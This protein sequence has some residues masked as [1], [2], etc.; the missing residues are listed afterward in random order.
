MVHRGDARDEWRDL[1]YLFIENVGNLV[2]PAI[3]DLGQAANVVALS[4][5]EGE[6]KPLKYPVMF[7][8]AD[9]VL[10]T[11]IDLLPHLP[12]ISLESHRGQPREGDA[13]AVVPAVSSQ[14]GEG[15]AAWSTWLE[16]RRVAVPDACAGRKVTAMDEHLERIIAADEDAR[17]HVASATHAATERIEHARAECRLRAEQAADSAS[18][19]AR[20]RAAQ[21]PDGDGSNHRGAPE[22]ARAI[23]GGST[24]GGRTH[25]G[26]G[27]RRLRADRA[28]G[29]IAPTDHVIA[30]GSLAYANARVRAL[31]SRLLGREIAA[32]VAA[33]LAA[34][35]DRARSSDTS[36][37]EWLAW[38]AVVLGS[39]PTGQA[40]VHSLLHRYDIENL[41][42]AWRAIVH[43]HAER[44]WIGHWIDLGRARERA[45]GRGSRL[46][47][48]RLTGRRRCGAR[49]L[50]RSPRPCG[51][52]TRTIRWPPRSAS[53]DGRRARS[54]TPLERCL[55]RSAPPPRS[56]G[57][58]VR[59]RDFAVVRR[60]GGRRPVTRDPHRRAWLPATTRSTPAS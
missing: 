1:D 48:A 51:A 47:H 52:R 31:K 39:Y 22:R 19:R 46:P 10:I 9:L 35:S 11:K 24:A 25:A 37:R 45:P 53:T 50:R 21:D 42:L 2:C 34:A 40:L 3:Y 26:R 55:P 59:E 28:R 7:R 36:R 6:D 16:D 12:G 14:T 41:K 49:R 57:A 58:V 33:G 18:R 60:A 29:R 56:P 4:V 38:Y 13:A 27:R 23:C 5:T 17:A 43:G 44:R 30:T 15:M 8:A 20:R 32:R 54:S